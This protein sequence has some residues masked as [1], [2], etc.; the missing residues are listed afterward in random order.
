MDN[1]VSH[2]A[3]EPHAHQIFEQSPF[4]I[5]SKKLAMWLFIMADVMTL[6]AC[7]A[8]YGFLRNATP[9]W[10]RPFHGLLG[11]GIMTVII[12]TTCLTL[13]I[14]LDAA[15]D[16]DQGRAFRWTM[17]TAAGGVL[18]SLLHIREW[19]EMGARGM[20]L[21]HNPWGPAAF[22][23]AYYVITGFSLLHMSVGSAALL[24]VGVRYR[25]GRYK[26]NDLEIMNIYWQFVT[27]AWLFIV[28]AVYLMNVAR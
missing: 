25:G 11:V 17:I 1:T 24:I 28:P 27:L 8:A 21:L 3:M 9:D 26:A 6:A 2:A 20:G 18:F 19:L 10:P 15:N 4:A 12:L 22:G 23:A 14:A 5:P 16:G 13:S 7:L